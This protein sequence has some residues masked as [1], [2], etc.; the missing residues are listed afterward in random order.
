MLIIAS[1]HPKPSVRG[2]EPHPTR[3]G[4]VAQNTVDIEE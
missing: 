3:G 2:E 4:P 1:L